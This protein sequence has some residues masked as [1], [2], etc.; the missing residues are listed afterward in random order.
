MANTKDKLKAGQKQRTVFTS[1]I[2]KEMIDDMNRGIEYSDNPFYEGDKDYKSGNVIFQMTDYEKEEYV[3]CSADPVYFIENYVPFENDHGVTLVKLRDYQKEFIEICGGEFWDEDYLEFIPI[4]RN[5][6]SLQARQCSKTTTM[7][8]IFLWYGIFHNDRHLAIVA[9]K[10][11][12]VIEIF[13]KMDSMLKNIPFFLKPGIIAK[14]MTG[15]SY[16]NGTFY[17]GFACTKTPAIGFS[18]QFLYIDEAALIPQNIMNEFWT[19]VY[20]TLSASKL[21]KIVLTSTP[22]GRQNKFYE[23]WDKGERGLNSFKT[24]RV[25]WWQVPEHDE[26][27][28]EQQRKDFGEVEFAQEF[29]LQWDVAASK[30]VRGTDMQ[31]MKRIKREY[32]NKDIDT[33]P[34]DVCKKLWWDP[35]FDPSSV[36][37]LGLKMFIDIDTAEG[38]ELT[39]QG[40]S[41]AD[42]NVMQLFVMELMSPLKVLKFAL[43][44]KIAW[45]DIFRF[46]QVG[47]YMDNNNDEEAMAKAAKYLVYGTFRSGRP[48]RAAVPMSMDPFGNPVAVNGAPV[49]TLDNVRILLEMNFNGKNFL[50]LFKDSDWWYDDLVLKT[51]HTKPVPGVK[52]KKKFGYKTTSGGNG[53][54]K[55][56]F[57]EEGAKMLTKRQIIVNHWN[58]DDPNECTISELGAFD[59]IKKSQLS[60]FY[61]YEGVGLHDDLAKTVL[62]CSRA[63]EIEE[64]VLWLQEYF[65]DADGKIKAGE[66]EWKFPMLQRIM[67]I[68]VDVDEGQLTDDEFTAMYTDGGATAGNTFARMN[69]G[70]PTMN[71]GAVPGSTYGSLMHRNATSNPYLSRQRAGNPYLNRGGSSN[72]YNKTA[73]GGGFGGFGRF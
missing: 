67:N 73:N 54:G 26:A 41:K 2:V 30:V 31:F 21:S 51:Y 12:T 18:I 60:K 64:F 34:E 62:D 49:K 45:K 44:K 52:Q 65:E 69:A 68:S 61:Q 19:A 33:I 1:K 35:S 28:A 22:R 57:C 4:Y 38:K 23:L 7:S 11:Q 48:E 15:L 25:D 56:Y 71:G 3:K 27:W 72:P 58:P 47:V 14:N 16:D 20:P 17:K 66:G 46:R 9:N 36:A 53:I 63:L 24:Y 6:I 42:Y 32:V 50:N 55:S 70:F 13:R 43:D 40:K 37:R 5:V 10:E 59:K 29:E 8:A 39:V